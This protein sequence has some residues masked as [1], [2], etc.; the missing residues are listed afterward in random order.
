MSNSLLAPN[1]LMRVVTPKKKVI[2][3][4]K[5][6]GEQ[7]SPETYLVNGA[8]IALFS[9][10]DV[11]ES[12][13]ELFIDTIEANVERFAGLPEREHL[14]GVKARVSPS[15][16]FQRIKITEEAYKKTT[17]YAE[18]IGELYT[19]IPEVAM[20]LLRHP[21][22][23]KG[24]ITD[25]VACQNQQVTTS[26]CRF[27]EYTG[28]ES[29]ERYY[30]GWCHSHGAMDAFHSRVDNKNVTR[31]VVSGGIRSSFTIDD[32]RVSVHY[33]PSLVVNAVGGEPFGAMGICYYSPRDE[34]ERVFLREV[35]IEFDEQRYGIR[36]DEELL[37]QHIVDYVTVYQDGR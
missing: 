21:E 29:E 1:E 18:L 26:S 7:E 35:D 8:E 13:R 3:G 16:V 20:H 34:E 19:P 22:A 32:F 33:L 4:W 6:S 27:T 9:D 12:T 24:T 31:S 17:A 30:A 28:L 15:E 25:V 36:D 2:D 14:P 23:P 37:L 10:K 11:Y 5:Y